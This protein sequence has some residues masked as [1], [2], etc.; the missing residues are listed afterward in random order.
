[1]AK[2]SSQLK[3]VWIRNEA[4]VLE[5]FVDMK[6]KRPVCGRPLLESLLSVEEDHLDGQV[7]ALFR[8]RPVRSSSSGLKIALH[9]KQSDTDG[10][11]I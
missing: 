6:K 3:L 10:F 2:G 9:P 5:P 11:E 1:M 4:E 7:S 8:K